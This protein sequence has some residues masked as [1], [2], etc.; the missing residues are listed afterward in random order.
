[1][2][3]KAHSGTSMSSN[4][5]FAPRES[6][7]S[8]QGA[9][10][11]STTMDGLTTPLTCS[12]PVTPG[13][14][15]PSAS[16]WLTRRTTSTTARS[17]SSTEASGRTV[18]VGRGELTDRTWAAIE[19]PVSG[20]GRRWRD[21]R[22]G[23]TRSCGS[24]APVRRGV[25]CPNDMDYGRP[26]MNGRGCGPRTAPG[27]ASWTRGSVKD[28]SVGDVEWILNVDSGVVRAHQ[29]AAGARKG[30]TGPRGGGRCRAASPSRRPRRRA[31][32]PRRPVRSP[33]SG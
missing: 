16:R 32:P 11:Y 4:V 9:N 7:P 25:T 14:Q 24:C 22:Q 23:S 26:R 10:G 31:R 8:E 27:H 5:T 1:M 18:V 20:S 33:V 30:V 28:D 12:V 3:R 2:E 19:P 13:H 6:A 17:R 21:H 15:S 29:H